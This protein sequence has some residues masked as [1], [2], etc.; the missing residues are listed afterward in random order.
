M[1]CIRKS[2]MVAPHDSRTLL[3]DRRSAFAVASLVLAGAGCQQILGL[4]D[5]PAAR[6]GAVADTTRTFDAPITHDAPAA[7]YHAT[8]VRFQSASNDYLYTGAL[9]NTPGS[10]RGTYSVWLRF[11]AGDA[12]QQFITVAQIA[13]AGGVFRQSDNTLEIVLF[14]CVG[15]KLLDVKTTQPY[16]TASGWIH[17]LA[18]WDVG[19][20]RADLYVNDVADRASNPTIVSGNICYDNAIKWGVGGLSSGQLDADVA[21]LY[22]S[23]GTYL[24]LSV[25]ANRRKFSSA[26]GKPIDLGATCGGPGLVT[27]GCLIGALATWNVNKGNAGGFTVGGGALTLAPT[28]PSD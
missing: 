18:S 14:D 5:L 7:G 15:A 12:Q 10:P 4:H 27:T 1:I 17:L 8:A 16:T 9:Q 2:V 22:A 25:D 28:S 6:D 21:D 26:A 20:S 11:S 24:D 19:A 13:V 3:R 23:L